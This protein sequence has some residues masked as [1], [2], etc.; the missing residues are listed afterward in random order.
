MGGSTLVVVAAQSQTGSGYLSSHLLWE[1]H[2]FTSLVMY[3]VS[4]RL[5]LHR[6]NWKWALMLM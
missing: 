1:N 2:P 6:Y 4:L 5:F 3:E